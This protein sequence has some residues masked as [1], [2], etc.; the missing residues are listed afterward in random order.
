MGGT[1]VVTTQGDVMITG[2]LDITGNVTI[3]NSFGS[4]VASLDQEGNATFSGSLTVNELR[5]DKIATDSATLGASVGRALL[6]A[7]SQ[8]TFIA[9]DRITDETLIYLTPLSSTGT[10]SLYV[11]GKTP[12]QGFTVALDAPLTTD[13]E[14][15]WWIVN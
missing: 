2:N 1:L 11:S 3:K 10:Q 12:G 6:T 9:N 4:V 14:F 5:F 8:T 13:V 15:N 7:G